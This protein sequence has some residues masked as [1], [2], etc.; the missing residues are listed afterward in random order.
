[1]P[2]VRVPPLRRSCSGNWQSSDSRWTFI[3]SMALS[4]A[5]LFVSLG[6]VPSSG[7]ASWSFR[8]ILMALIFSP[9]CL[10]A[11]SFCPLFLFC[12]PVFNHAPAL[13]PVYA[14]RLPTVF[15][16]VTFD[17]F[18][19]GFLDLGDVC[20]GFRSLFFPKFFLFFF[21]LSFFIPQ[22]FFMSGKACSRVFFFL[23]NLTGAF[24]PPRLVYLCCCWL[25]RFVR[26][27]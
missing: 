3:V 27:A 13:T 20:V 2:I 6:P 23:G 21:A 15:F 14:W 17:P 18:Q 19:S 4:W 25:G 1:V 24:D 16:L 22:S 10:F 26:L 12:P 5:F 7:D 9:F 11:T 8:Y